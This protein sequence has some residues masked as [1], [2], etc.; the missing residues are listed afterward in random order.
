MNTDEERK[1]L[2]KMSFT[3]EKQT[4]M[5]ETKSERRKIKD[6][7]GYNNNYNSWSVVNYRS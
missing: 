1:L 3:T 5:T 7:G 4:V 2:A 6:I